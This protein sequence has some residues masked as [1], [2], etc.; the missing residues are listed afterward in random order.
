MVKCI[1]CGNEVPDSIDWNERAKHYNSCNTCWN[2]WVKYSIMVI[3]DLRLDMSVAEHRQLLKKYERM[4]FGVEK[5]EGLRD[6]SREEER[7]PD[8]R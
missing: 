6:V 3:N 2:E 4:F 1:R 5:L 7:V 8:K